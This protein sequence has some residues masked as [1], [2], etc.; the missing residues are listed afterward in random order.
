[1]DPKRLVRAGYDRLSYVYRTE[2]GGACGH[3]YVPWI[4]KLYKSLG[5]RPHTLDLGCGCGVPVARLLASRG[6]V[7]GVDISPVQ[8]DRA[9]ELVPGARFICDDMCSVKFPVAS[10]DAVVSFYSIIH[11]PIEE[12]EELFRRITGWLKPGGF[13][14]G[15]LGGTAWTGTEKDW[16]GVEGATM[17]WSHADAET[18]RRWLEGAG[19]EVVEDEFVLEGDGGHHLFC[20][21]L[22]GPSV[23][24]V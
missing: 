17:Y 22:N 20:A 18:Y 19:L 6:D 11:V 21:K 3:D 9:R 7:T 15:T 24:C 12:H 23:P 8:V 4:D 10:F 1:M 14:V 5:P 13:F 2:T 16:L